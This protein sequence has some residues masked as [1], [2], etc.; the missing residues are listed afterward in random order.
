MPAVLKVRLERV[1]VPETRVMLPVVPPLSSAT[2]ALPSVVVMVTL[3]V[4]VPA[5][6]QLASTALTM[7]PLAMDAPAT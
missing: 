4:A 7:I 6:F 2:V 1:R 3:F 5:R